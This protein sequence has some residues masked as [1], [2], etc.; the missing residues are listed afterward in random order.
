MIAKFIQ[1]EILIDSTHVALQEKRHK[2]KVYISDMHWF[3]FKNEQEHVNERFGPDYNIRIQKSNY[4]SIKHAT[5]QFYFPIN[6][7][8]KNG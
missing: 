5:Y 6:S 3:L 2:L 1:Y 7:K 4:D 8:N